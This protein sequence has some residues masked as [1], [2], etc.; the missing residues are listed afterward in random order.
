MFKGKKGHNMNMHILIGIVVLFGL[1]YLNQTYQW[2]EIPSEPQSLAILI[3]IGAF[4]S[5]M[6]DSDQPGSIINKYIT[7]ALVGIIIWAFYVG[8]NQYGI[9][10]AVILGLLRI[11]EHRTIIHSVLGAIVI[12]APLFYLG[13]IY[14]IVGFIAYLSHII[15][16]GEMS[17]GWEKDWW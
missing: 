4:Y 12:S 10:A 2:V 1:W 13:T 3:S 5:L 16:D 8:Q 17:L 9:M 11:I 7:L 15:S 6:P 14:F